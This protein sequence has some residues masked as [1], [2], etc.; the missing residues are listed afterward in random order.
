MLASELV[1]NSMRHSGSAVPGGVVTVTVAVVGGA[2]RI[3]ATDRAGDCVSVLP[4]VAL[5]DRQAEG[6]RGMRLVEA[7]SERWGYQR[8]GGF[9]ATWFELTVG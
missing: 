8:G 5:A 4:P 7:L 6:G 1:T 2:V 3:E 9:A